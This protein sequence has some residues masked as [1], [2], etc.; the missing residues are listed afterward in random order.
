VFEATLKQLVNRV[1]G[2]RG[3]AV[4]N[5][6]GIVLEAVDEKGND[7]GADAALTEFAPVIGQL[8]GAAESAELGEPTQLTLEGVER[9]TL[10]RSLTD[11]YVAA[12]HVSPD[13]LIGKAHFHLRVAAPDLAREL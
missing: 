3:A 9:T 7:L 12:L 5:L 8:L 4:L 10:V 13:S 1:D 2:A 11:K 6:D